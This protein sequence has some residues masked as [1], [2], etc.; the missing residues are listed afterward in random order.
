[1]WRGS[2][3]DWQPLAR[4]ILITMSKKSLTILITFVLIILLLCLAA[5]FFL[6]GN[7]SGTGTG[8]TGFRSFLPFG[9]SSN[10]NP[11]DQNGSSNNNQGNQNPKGEAP[12]DPN[13]PNNP[14]G[15]NPADVTKK[16]RK[17]SNAPVSGA[18][19]FDIK[20]GTVV[21]YVDKAT[22]H[23]YE[24]EMFSPKFDRI[25]N[26]TMPMSYDALWGSSGAA[27]IAR[28]LSQDDSEVETY[29]VNV[30]S[31]ATSTNGSISGGEL[32]K[33]ISDV[34]VK[35]TSI[36]YL[37]KNTDG[38]VGVTSNIDG[39]KNKTVWTSPM[40]ELTTQFVNTKTVAINTKPAEDMPGYLYLVDITTGATTRPLGNVSGLVSLVSS[41]VFKIIYLTQSD[42][43]SLQIYD[44]KKGES[45]F[46][47][48]TTFP[49]KCV[50]GNKNP[51]VIYCGVPNEYTGKESLTKWYKGLASFSDKI[52]TYNSKDNTST[53]LAD[54]TA[55]SGEKIDVVK[56]ILSENDQYLFFI[57]RNDGFLW[58]LDLSTSTQKIN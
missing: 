35:G 41:D 43:Y 44:I 29:S 27:F 54:L 57:N 23:I 14:N 34:S 58:S 19:T 13:N 38:S 36:F 42:K 39:S 17:L 5:Y 6:L 48:F 46:M 52:W 31:T 16:L 51:S 22:G 9:D 18:G 30:K 4:T 33:N 10:N 50:W 8:I 3:I 21:R 53:S 37:V 32:P 1:M 20:A 12:S 55:D 25:S 26:V 28:R 24:I 11:D 49:E 15:F 47:P 56:P 40:K 7:G 2:A 45:S